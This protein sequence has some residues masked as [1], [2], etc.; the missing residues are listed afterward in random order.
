MFLISPLKQNVVRINNFFGEFDYGLVAVRRQVWR[1][2]H[3][4]FL[5]VILCRGPGHGQIQDDF[6]GGLK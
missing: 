3:I 2:M 4:L 1:G 6:W 5:R